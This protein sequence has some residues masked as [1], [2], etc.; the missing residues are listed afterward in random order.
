MKFYGELLI[1]V[2]LLLTNLRVFFVNH[3]RRDPLVALAPLTFI[4]TILQIFSWG[5]D[6]FTLLGLLLGLLVFLSNFHAIFRYVERLYIDHYS[7]LMKTWAVFTVTLSLLAIAITFVFRPVELNKNKIGITENITR[8]KGNFRTGFEK[9]PLF[10]GSDAIMYEYGPATPLGAEEAVE[11]KALILFVPDKRGDSQSYK[12]YLQLLAKEGYNVCST[13][14]YANDLRWIHTFEDMKIIRR[15]SSIIRSIN[16]KQW[17]MAQREFYTYNI[18]QEFKALTAIIDEKYGKETKFYLV[19]DEM[20]S[21]ALSDFSKI[22]EE[23]IL[24]TFSLDTISEYKTPGYGCIEQ[25]D[26]LLALFMELKRD[27]KLRTPQ[28]MVEKT[29]EIIKPKI[30]E[31]PEISETSETSE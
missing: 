31:N 1:F 27:P 23:R 21:T 15:I 10:S 2:L 7:P 16:N 22:H 30:A 29:L 6:F 12:P 20:G 24:G 8:F 14:F 19:T 3:V 4:L 9:A 28:L 25:T 18:M 5:V 13:D 26:P 11:P 17:Y